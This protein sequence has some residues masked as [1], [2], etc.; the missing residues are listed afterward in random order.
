MLSELLLTMHFCF[1]TKNES[2]QRILRALSDRLLR[3]NVDDLIKHRTTLTTVDE[4]LKMYESLQALF[5]KDFTDAVPREI[6][7]V[8]LFN[9][10]LR[11]WWEH[12]K[13]SPRLRVGKFEAF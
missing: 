7:N 3:K 1:Q 2:I 10:N 5:G 12:F 6:G 13:G 8:E 9:E 11:R 4:R